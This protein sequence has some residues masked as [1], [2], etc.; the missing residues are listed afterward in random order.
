MRWARAA[1]AAAGLA[2]VTAVSQD[3]RAGDDDDIAALLNES[4]VSGASKGAESSSDAPATVVTLT[5]EDMQRHGMRSL[6]EAINFLGMGLVT[7]D[8]LHSVEIGGRGV[9]LTADYGN[10]VLVVVDGH[11]L[12]EA[13]DG[14]A[15]VEQGLGIPIELI[16][17]VELILGPG[18]VLYGGN[19]MLGV[20][21]VVT[22][23]A[24]SYRGFH[25][26]AEVGASP[27]QSGGS[28]TGF[29]PGDLGTTVRVGA[30]VGHEFSLFGSKGEV[31]AQLEYY[32]QNGPSFGW[33][34]ER[35][36]GPGGQPANF[37]PN[38]PLGTWGGVTHNQYG[39]EIPTGYARVT[40]GDFT[41]SL[42]GETYFRTTPYM[43]GFNQQISNFDDPS[44]YELDRW[45]SAD[46]QYRKAITSRLSVLGRL[47]GDTYDYQQHMA[48]AD[49]SYCSIPVR[50]ACVQQDIGVSRWAGLELQ[51]SYDWLG[52]GKLTTMLGED[53]RVRYVGA[54]SNY[55][56]GATNRPVGSVGAGHSLDVPLGVYLQQ[57]WTP[58]DRLH[59]NAGARFDSDPRGGQRLSPRA[60]AV[61]DVWKGGTLKAIYAEA[62]RAPTYYEFY[63][64]SPQQLPNPGLKPESVR[65]VEA[66]L[67]QKWG[68]QRLLFGV[69]R[70]WWSDMVSFE[71]VSSA[72][73]GVFQYAN[74]S[75]I[76]NYGYNGAFEGQVGSLRYGA[77]LTGAYTKRSTPSGVV[78]LTVAPQVFGNARLSYALPSP[79]PTFAIASSLVGPRLADRALDGNFPTVPSAPLA[80]GL[81]VAV[82]GDVPHVAGLGYR[83]AWD[84]STASVSPYVAGPIQSEDPTIANRPAAQLAPVNRM[85]AF[86]TLRYTFPW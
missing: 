80:L 24:R 55:F 78:P 63:Y 22:K 18:S 60:A 52:T 7:Q 19:A 12:N 37:G 3:A 62:F 28:L 6:A 44:S 23:R 25:A 11:S 77:S 16:D 4:V 42:R 73:G 2:L 69:F 10:H 47:Y 61:L 46:L 86:A 39:T 66:S 17:H 15:Y 34:R 83:L 9:L 58:F 75:S 76:D 21:N 20:I 13:W 43:N 41:L 8:P 74:T 68:A 49:S 84:Y 35:V 48:V 71:Q 70:S 81:R 31:T 40:L 51:G 85:S 67:E 82:S 54:T 26:V 65:G 14:T 33:T 79:L 64:A 59:L 38:A 27:G 57:R 32:T 30:G 53:T 50:G 29:G 36:T 56:D 5:S 72:N 1:L 45:L